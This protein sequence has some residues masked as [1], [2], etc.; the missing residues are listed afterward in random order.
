MDAG[1]RHEPPG[2]ETEDFI[3][4]RT[5]N[6]QWWVKGFYK[7]IIANI[8]ECFAKVKIRLVLKNAHGFS[9]M[10]VMGHLNNSC[11]GRLTEE[12]PDGLD[13][14]VE[15]ESTFQEIW[16]E[17]QKNGSWKGIWSLGRDTSS[18]LRWRGAKCKQ[19]RRNR[20]GEV[21]LEGEEYLRTWCS[22]GELGRG[23]QRTWEIELHT[24]RSP[25]SLKSKK[26]EDRC[27]RD[28]LVRLGGGCY[29][30][31]NIQVKARPC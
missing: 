30:T 16:C 20:Q 5:T 18:D 14:E 2:T 13:W 26:E 15:Y 11:F 27:R 17:R 25:L 23:L 3:I 9:D 21:S 29:A 24:G 12:K 19:E 4:H 22:Y 6:S 10:E 28:G 1:T 31:I 8:V 7:E